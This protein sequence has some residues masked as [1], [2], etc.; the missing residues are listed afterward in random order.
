MSRKKVLDEKTTSNPVRRNP[1]AGY[2][3]EQ[4]QQERQLQVRENVAITKWIN[5]FNSL[6]PIEINVDE[7]YSPIMSCGMD[8]DEKQTYQSFLVHIQ[9]AGKAPSSKEIEEFSIMVPGLDQ[10]KPY[11]KKMVGL[12]LSALIET[13]KDNEF[14]I[15]ITDE[16]PLHLC[17]RNRKEVTVYGDLWNVGIEMTTGRIIVTGNVEYI[18]E[19]I[20]GGEIHVNGT[21]NNVPKKEK[22]EEFPT[23][24]GGKVYVNGELVF[25]GDS[26]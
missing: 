11:F 6:T 14:V 18:G 24:R 13:S 9:Y 26:K 5:L 3:S 16:P 15:H 8:I 4:E 7:V 19:Y 20:S 22:N 23:Y 12:Y 25:D 10:T 1:F 17:F 21:L 2:K